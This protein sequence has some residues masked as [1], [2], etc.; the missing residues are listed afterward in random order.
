[1]HNIGVHVVMMMTQYLCTTRETTL[2][3]KKGSK[4]L[5][6][7]TGGIKS[8]PMNLLKGILFCSSG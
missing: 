1:M 4:V 2:H 7:T 8:S 5:P 6:K 3:L